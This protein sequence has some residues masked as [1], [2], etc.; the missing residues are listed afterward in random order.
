MKENNLR[1]WLNSITPRDIYQAAN[2]H[3]KKPLLSISGPKET[4]KNLSVYWREE[5]QNNNWFKYLVCI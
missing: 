3:L 2:S 1:T 4:L 5:I